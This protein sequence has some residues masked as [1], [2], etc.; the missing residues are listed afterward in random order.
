MPRKRLTTEEILGPGYYREPFSRGLKVRRAAAA[1]LALEDPDV[2]P[3]SRKAAPPPRAA[4]RDYKTTVY[5]RESPSIDD[6]AS[7]ALKN[8]TR[9]KELLLKAI[10]YG[11]RVPRTDIH[12]SEQ[13][14][15]ALGGS[16]VMFVAPAAGK[17][18]QAAEARWATRPTGHGQSDSVDPAAVLIEWDVLRRMADEPLDGPTDYGLLVLAFSHCLGVLPTRVEL[19]TVS[20]AD[21]MSWLY[22]KRKEA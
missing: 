6:Y 9:Y 18:F 19:V 21:G 13:T 14:F 22:R 12:A 17:S 8:Q 2:D 7:R 1:S 5:R 15:R 11:M 16:S 4:P 3:Y 10:V 20:A